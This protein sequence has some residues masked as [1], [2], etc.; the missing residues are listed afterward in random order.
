LNKEA[1]TEVETNDNVNVPNI[2]VTDK[3]DRLKKN[4]GIMKN[5]LNFMSKMLKM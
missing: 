4:K 2:N 5:K 1:L 3:L